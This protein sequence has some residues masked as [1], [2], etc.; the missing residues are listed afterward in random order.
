[1]MSVL[2]TPSRSTTQLQRLAYRLPGLSRLLGVSPFAGISTD[3]VNA[4]WLRPCVGD[5]RRLY[6]DL[7]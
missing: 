2:G 6:I 1:M 7:A 3:P 4:G 5:Q